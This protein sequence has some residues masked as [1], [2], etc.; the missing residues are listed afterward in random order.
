MIQNFGVRVEQRRHR[1][2]T[3]SRAFQEIAGQFVQFGCRVGKA[4]EIMHL[5]MGHGDILNQQL[6]FSRAV[7]FIDS[8]LRYDIEFRF[9]GE[10]DRQLAFSE[11]YG[12]HR[13]VVLGD[14]KPQMFAV[15]A[16]RLAFHQLRSTDQQTRTGI[17]H[18]EGSQGFHLLYGPQADFR[19]RAL[20]VVHHGRHKVLRQQDPCG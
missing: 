15:L 12:F 6:R 13:S 14:R 11:S 19:Q 17:S 4:P 16:D 2:R 18:A 1:F 3:E 9:L 8:R 5:Q 20:Q 7:P 10:H